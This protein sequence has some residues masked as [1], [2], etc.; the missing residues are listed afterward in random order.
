M[1]KIITGKELQDTQYD[2]LHKSCKW[3]SF[4]NASTFANNNKNETKAQVAI[5][6][7]RMLVLRI[8]E[9]SAI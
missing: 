2:I 7:S 3:S 8:Y 9:V 6:S 5:S 1:W 4:C